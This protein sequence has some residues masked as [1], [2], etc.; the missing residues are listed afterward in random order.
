[1]GNLRRTDFPQP[2][3]FHTIVPFRENQI[4]MFGGAYFQAASH[5]HVPV[6]EH[7]WSFNFQTLQWSLVASLDLIRP[8]YF[9]ASA[10]NSNGEVWTHGGVIGETDEEG[11]PVR[12]SSI[13]HLPIQM[14]K[15]GEIVWKKFLAHLP[16]RRRLI[17]EPQLMR[18]LNIPLR[19][20]RRVY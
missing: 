15:L 1:M 17:N 20:V 7:V 10:L 8:I 5:E 6:D 4:L 9:Q 18:E 3:K 2:R 14:T 11:H 12:I 16:D 19:F 13:Y